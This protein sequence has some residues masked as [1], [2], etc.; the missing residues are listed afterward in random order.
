M[1][2]PQHQ[3]QYR[4]HQTYTTSIPDLDIK[5][6]FITFVKLEQWHSL[7]DGLCEQTKCR[8]KVQH[9]AYY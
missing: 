2:T 5:D 9:N 6:S 1:P 3:Y 8:F 7:L 4:L